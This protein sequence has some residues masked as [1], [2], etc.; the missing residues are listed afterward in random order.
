MLVPTESFAPIDETT[1]NLLKEKHPP[2]H[3]GSV[4][5]TSSQLQQAAQTPLVIDTLQVLAAIQSFPTGSASGPGGL[6]PQHIKNLIFNPTGVGSD[7]FPYCLAW[8]FI[9][10][11][12]T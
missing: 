1:L 9:S 3:P 10:W 11:F 12:A 5:P 2:Q 8:Q 7:L 4:F 6:R